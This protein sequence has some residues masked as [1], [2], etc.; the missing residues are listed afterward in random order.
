MT[1]EIKKFYRSRTDRILFGVAGGLGKYFGVDPV[2]FRLLFIV[3]AL[4]FNGAGIL[5]YAIAVFVTSSE[6]QAANGKKDLGGEFEEL[7]G[8]ID[9]KAR[10]IAGE[11]DPADRRADKSR[12]ALGLFLILL[13]LF[14]LAR[15]FFP[16]GW[17]DADLVWS[18]LIILAGLYIIF[19]K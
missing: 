7:A 19:K 6:P 16:L 1:E 15:E 3:L 13:G 12:T 17:F 11:F 9:S 14:F 18:L 2:L 5:L 8:K 10:E 4:S